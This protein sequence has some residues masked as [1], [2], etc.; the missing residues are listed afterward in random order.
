MVAMMSLTSHWPQCA[1]SFEEVKSFCTMLTAKCTRARCRNGYR[2]N[3]DLAVL[4]SRA[5]LNNELDGYADENCRPHLVQIEECDE[6][7]L[8]LPMILQ[9]IF[10]MKINKEMELN[11]NNPRKAIEI[12]RDAKTVYYHS[13][14]IN[15]KDCNCPITFGGESWKETQEQSV[16]AAHN[17]M[18]GLKLQKWVTDHL[19]TVASWYNSELSVSCLL[20]EC[21]CFLFLF[22]R[23]L[24]VL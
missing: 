2:L 1:Y 24:S 7:L 21:L 20:N 19:L 9:D 8:P 15:G 10:Q 13:T 23:V 3:A 4:W 17:T 6:I 11:C 22:H 18:Q 12:R 14:I 16:R 5:K